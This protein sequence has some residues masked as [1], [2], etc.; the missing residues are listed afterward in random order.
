MNT[1]EPLEIKISG[2]RMKLFKKNKNMFI[3]YLVF[4]TK[5]CKTS[6]EKKIHERN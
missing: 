6:C 5:P 2:G 1:L 4:S 3:K